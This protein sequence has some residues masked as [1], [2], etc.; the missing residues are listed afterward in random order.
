MGNDSDAKAPFANHEP[1]HRVT[2]S[3]DFWIDTTEVTV[4]MYSACVTGGACA[5][6]GL[7]GQIGA[8]KGEALYEKFQR[9][10]NDPNDAAK[11]QYPANCVDQFQAHDYCAYVNKRL[12]T[13]AEWEYAARGSDG[14]TWPWGEA[15]PDCLHAVTGR[16]CQGPLA[17]GSVP[18]GAS[19]VGALDMAGN[20]FEW[21]E[22]GL[23]P[24]PSGSG[25]TGRTESEGVECSGAA[26]GH[27]AMGRLGHG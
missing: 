12:P 19:P 16:S 1:S 25:S 5:R 13:E 14:R 15:A 2:M 4:A 11:A 7:H 6:A 8:N 3:R 22:G 27:L 24:Y 17:V 10:C 21:V 20:V 26:A 23:S 9:Q 18:E